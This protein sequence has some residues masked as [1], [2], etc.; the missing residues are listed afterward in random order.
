MAAQLTDRMLR[1]LVALAALAVIAAAAYLAYDRYTERY[2]ATPGPEGG[3]AVDQIVSAR[4]AEMGR[5]QVAQLS[6]TVQ[7]T[8]TDTRGFGWLESRQ[9]A[10]MPYS[11]D[12]LI[13]LS[14]IGAGDLH[15]DA[16]SRT[17][18]VDAPDIIVAPPN[19]DE[20]ERSL[21]ET[22]GVFV[23]RKAAEAL[24]KKVSQHAKA[25]AAREAAKPRWV[26]EAQE[27]GRAAIARLMAAPLGAIGY[28]DAR[29]I[30]T[31]PGERRDGERWDVSRSVEEVVGNAR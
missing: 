22:R 30:V 27:K 26:K 1:L 13:D 12:Y 10:K 18:R 2:V 29:I 4:L 20:A 3:P 7:S 31:Y 16:A 8:A 5:L 17:L 19:T 24:S 15:W 21:V 6:G 28:P 25:G 14:Q 11:V 9:V 23:T